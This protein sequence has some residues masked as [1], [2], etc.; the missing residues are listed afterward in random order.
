MYRIIGGD[1]Q[2]YGPVSA[3]EVRQWIAEGRLNAQSRI[4]PD[5][6]ADWTTLGAL[7][8]F[9][10]SPP[11]TPA[12]TYT[13]APGATAAPYTMPGGITREEALRRVRLPALGLLVTGVLATLMAVVGVVVRLLAMTGNLD[14]SGL[15]PNNPDL[16]PLWQQLTNSLQQP[17][18]LIFELIGLFIFLVVVFGALRLRALRSFG[19]AV[20]VSILAMIPCQ[21]CCVLGLPFG[22]WALT[23]INKPEVKVHFT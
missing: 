13:P 17:F 8:E 19:L 12:P 20:G 2:E 16:A 18:G 5:G 9:A 4:R 3:S 6:V 21:C 7:P 1:G 14:L 22:I 23:V 15:V 10:T 11:P